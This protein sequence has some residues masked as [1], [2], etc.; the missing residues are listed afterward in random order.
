MTK[1]KHLICIVVGIILPVGIAA[2][3]IC[4]KCAGRSS[5]S[6]TQTADNNGRTDIKMTQA[7]YDSLM[8][9][10]LKEDEDTPPFQN[11]SSSSAH[12]FKY[13]SYA[14]IVAFGKPAVPFAMAALQENKPDY[15]D[16]ILIRL[17]PD[18]ALKLGSLYGDHY[19]Y[20]DSINVR[21]T[22]LRWW[23]DFGSKQ[24]WVAD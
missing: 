12:V 18:V 6:A 10:L 21:A 1:R 17:L 19:W 15:S 11:V 13:R 2:V 22:W 5:M 24:Q 8:A 9:E 4:C 14:K 20:N 16:L 7:T 3:V 23:M